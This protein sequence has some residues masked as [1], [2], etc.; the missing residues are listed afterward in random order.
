MKRILQ[1]LCTVA[2]VLLLTGTPAL[3]QSVTGSISGTVT[4]PTGAAIQRATVT[5]VLTERNQTLRTLTTSD[6]GFYAA[7]ALP[8]GTYD[9]HIK[10]SG[11]TAEEVQSIVLHANDTLTVNRE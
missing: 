3:A 1:Y 7:S 6:T 9:V 2:A 11:F 10:A 8:V 4:D 5:I